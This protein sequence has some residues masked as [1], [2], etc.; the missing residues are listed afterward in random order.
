[1]FGLVSIRKYNEMVSSYE[2][3]LAQLTK[4]CE[5]A[6]Q[7]K[8]KSTQPLFKSGFNRY[9]KVTTGQMVTTDGSLKNEVWK[10]IPGT[11]WQVSNY[12][13]I[14]DSQRHLTKQD[15][16]NNGKHGISIPYRDK[17][18]AFRNLYGAPEAI[19]VYAFNPHSFQLTKSCHLR[20]KYIDGNP[21]NKH[22]SN[23]IF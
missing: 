21:N 12:C 18:G 22:L 5:E 11:N 3:K 4:E 2:A 17:N 20:L 6:T 9:T 1:M 16:K 7:L 15:P 14:L 23:I 8:K 19:M 13:R 10:P